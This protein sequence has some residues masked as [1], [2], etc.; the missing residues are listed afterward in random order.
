MQPELAVYGADFRRLDQPGM[1][2]GHR[3]Q[4]AFELLEPEIEEFVQLREYRAPVIAL[5]DI[6]LQKP[7]VIWPPVQDVGCRQSLPFEL[8]AKVFRHRILGNHRCPPSPWL[9][10]SET[11]SFIASLKFE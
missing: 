8:L 4:W 5:P 3:V 10:R 6:G 9:G 2:H 7:G 1:R 11:R